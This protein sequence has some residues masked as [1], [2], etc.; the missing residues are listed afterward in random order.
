MGKKKT[1]DINSREV[2]DTMY[3][4]GI[5]DSLVP[6]MSVIKSWTNDERAAIINWCCDI[7]D[8]EVAIKPDC[9]EAWEKSL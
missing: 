5:E 4:I 1:E 2:W 9:L 6:P 8:G 7:Q 3:E